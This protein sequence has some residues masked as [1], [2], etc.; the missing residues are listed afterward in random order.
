MIMS[1][2][3]LFL[4]T[5]PKKVSVLTLWDDRKQVVDVWTEHQTEHLKKRLHEC[6]CILDGCRD[7]ESCD[8]YRQEADD[9]RDL[10]KTGKKLL[11][12]GSDG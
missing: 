12:E 4:P 1:I 3:K 6:E 9:L 2:L 7:Q 11:K 8:Y 5:K 10:I